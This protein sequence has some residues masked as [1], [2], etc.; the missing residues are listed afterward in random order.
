MIEGR[1]VAT[2]RIAVVPVE[3]T[4]KYKTSLVEAY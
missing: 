1:Q 2:L 4:A 3:I